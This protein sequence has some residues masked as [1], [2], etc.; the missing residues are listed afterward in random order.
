[1]ETVSVV[2]AIQTTAVCLMLPTDA[3][4][5]LSTSTTKL[6]WLLPVLLF[7]LCASTPQSVQ[8][9][10]MAST[11]VSKVPVKVSASNDI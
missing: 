7:V 10:L 9:V 3:F 8:F 2:T 4:L 11:S 5:F 1:M 6:P